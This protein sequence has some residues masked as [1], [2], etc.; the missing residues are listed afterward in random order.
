MLQ[1]KVTIYRTYGTAMLRWQGTEVEFVGARK[2]SYSPE[3]RNPQVEPGSLEDDQRRRDFTINA[4]AWSL[5]RDSF[6]ELVDP[7]E[8]MYDLEAFTALR[9][10]KYCPE[11]YRPETGW[12]VMS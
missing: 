1:A 10:Q 5:N 2:E 12:V 7:F 9:M 3:S 11:G 6:G 4:M 8:G